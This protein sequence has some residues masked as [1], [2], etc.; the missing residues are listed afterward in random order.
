MRRPTSIV[1]SLKQQHK[2]RKRD[3]QRRQRR[4]LLTE[5][6]EDRRL[7]AGPDIIAIR[8]D[9]APLLEDG[10]TL[11]V[12][13]R[14]FNLLF[15]GGAD[16]DE[17]TIL[18][19]TTSGEPSIQLI[20]SGGDG[21]FTDGNE[22]VV[23]LGYVGVND[24]GSTDPANLQQLVLRPASSAA[25]NAT[26]PSVGMPDDTYRIEIFGDLASN[27]TPLRNGSGEAFRD[28]V[29]D[30][31][32]NGSDFF[33][34]FRLARGAQVV[35][36][37]PQPVS[38]NTYTLQ[39]D[40]NAT[41]GQFRVSV[42]GEVTGQILLSGDVR[43]NIEDAI[44]A[45]PNIQGVDANAHAP[46]H[47]AVIDLGTTPPSWEFQFKGQFATEEPVLAVD[48][49]DLTGPGSG[50][51]ITRSGELSQATDQ[52]LVYF[53][54]DEL[55][56]AAAED[57]KFYQLVYTAVSGSTADD[58]MLLP[59]RVS[60]DSVDNKA[61]LTFE[62]IPD[63][64]YRLDVGT[65]DESDDATDDVIRI[66]TLFNKTPFVN[67]A[68]ASFERLG[69]LGDDNATHNN[70][71]DVD[72][73]EF[74]VPPG[75]ATINV[76]AQPLTPG[77]DVTVAIA[78]Q[79]LPPNMAA[80]VTEN[81]NFALA[82]GTYT[83]QIENTAGFGAYDLQVSSTANIS[84]SDNN[85]TFAAATALG[86][87]GDAGVLFAA[88]IEPQNQGIHPALPQLPG[89]DDEPG[90]RH[91]QE[92]CHIPITGGTICDM[93]PATNPL[94]TLFG[95]PIVAT[96]P[97]R[98]TDIQDWYY[99][100]PSD[101]TDVVPGGPSV[102]D[103]LGLPYPNLISEPEKDVI[104][105]IYELYGSIA[106]I[107]FIEGRDTSTNTTM[108]LKGDLLAAGGTDTSGP[109]GILG[110]G[111]PAFLIMD[112]IDFPTS[113]VQFGDL[114]FF[115]AFH[116]VGHGLGLGHS[117]DL[118]SVMNALAG[119][120]PEQGSNQ[121]V[122]PGDHDV[123]HFQRLWRP[124]STDIDLY[125][126]ETE[127]DGYFTAEIYAERL[128]PNGARDDDSS[129][130]DSVLTLY[131][132]NLDGSREVIARNDNY[133]SNDSFVGLELEDGIYYL[134]VSST[135]NVN[136]DPEI[137]DSGFG[138]ATQ[139]AYELL[140]NLETAPPSAIVDLDGELTDSAGTRLD[141]DADGEPG[142][143]YHFW[144][145]A[146]Q[147]TIFADKA[148]NTI[149][150][151]VE[152]DGSSA[153]PYDTL[154]S[155]DP[156][157]PGAI[158]IA[159]H[160]LVVPA[161]WD[162][163]TVD[164]AVATNMLST[165]PAAITDGQTF[166]VDDGINFPV[167]FEFETGGGVT[168]GN[169]PVSFTAGDDAATVAAAIE[170]AIDLVAGTL[171][172]VGVDATATNEVVS[173]A[174]ISLLDERG[175][176]G[177]LSAPNI[178]RIVGNSG[179][180]GD[181][182]TLLDNRPYLL[183]LDASNDALADGEVLS[184][185]QGVT[186]MIDGG[187]LFKIKKSNLDVGTSSLGLNRAHAALQSLGTPQAQVHLDSYHN[188][189]V[190]GNS[191]GPGLVPVP[192]DF[193][194]IVLRGDSDHEDEG[195]FLN[196]VNHTNITHG[197]GLVPINADDL[198]FAPVHIADARPTVS[199][200]AI[201]N[202]ASS[203]LSANPNSFDDA[204]GRLGPDIDGN[205][206]MDNSINGL[207]IRIETDN[208][209]P[210]EKLL[211]GARFDDNDITH[212][213]T[214]NL[215][216]AG[217]AGG[218]TRENRP[219][220]PVLDLEIV[221]RLSG[222]LHIDPGTVIKLF[223]SRIELERGASNL[224]AEGNA[225]REVIFTSIDDDRFGGS[226]SFDGN[227][228]GVSTGSPGDWA[229]LIFQ[230]S[231]S[232][233]IDEALIAFG[234]GNV[235]IEGTS[236]SFNAIEV[237]QAELRLTNSV[238]ED[239]ASGLE[240]NSTRNGRGQNEATTI[241]VR[242]AQPVVVNNVI[243]DNAGSVISINDNSLRAEIRSDPGRA[244]GVI[245]AFDD[246]GDNHGPLIR[247]NR[248]GNDPANNAINGMEIRAST[249]LTTASVWD[250]TDIVHVL[251]NDQ[252]VVDN[253]HTFGG[254]RLQSSNSESLVVKL[255]G[256]TSA[257]F[258]ATG[259]P[260]EI[261]DRIGGTLQILGS[262]GHPVVITS[263]ADDT[264]GAGFTPSGLPLFD[265]NN[266]GPSTASLTAPAWNGILLDQF[267]NDRN[268]TVV[269]EDEDVFTQ[270][271]DVNDVSTKAQSLGVLAVNEKDGT[272]ISR[273][274]FEVHGA[275]ALDDRSDVDSYNFTAIAGTE[276]WID[277]DQTSSNLDAVVELVSNTGTVLV[278]SIGN[279]VAQNISGLDAFPLAEDV[280][281]GRDEYTTNFRDP[282]MRVLLP[283]QFGEKG[284]YF[285]RVRSNPAAG[286]ITNLEGGLTTGQY[287]LQIRLRQV[288][289]FSGSTV[290]LADIRYAQNGVSL[291]GLPAHSP[292]VSDASDPA[293]NTATIDLGNFLES[294][295]AAINIAGNLNTSTEDQRF[296]FDFNFDQPRGAA[297]RPTTAAV[298]FDVDYA[299]RVTRAD[300]TISVFDSA[301][302]L[303]YVG[304]ESNISDDQERPGQSPDT[305]E[306]DRGSF[307]RLDPF[308]GPVHLPEGA[309]NY[310]VVVGSNARL[311]NALD[312]F[313]QSN[314]TA[315]LTRLEAD[316]GH[317]PSRRRPHRFP[318]ATS[319]AARRR[320]R[321][322]STLTRPP[323]YS[324]T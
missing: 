228:N 226:G 268:V 307:S 106:G 35:A 311:P 8:P 214:E 16:I 254:L 137:V 315:P 312:Q 109:G 23:D 171:L 282:G 108:V 163:Q 250:D 96:D 321:T 42:D 186:T 132:E 246:L 279:H 210:V 297:D 139:G 281:L 157:M 79:P 32:D 7:L 197:G 240:A 6:L 67:G 105:E 287:R 95:D 181:I 107:Q 40:G 58:T 174:N 193:G 185:P 192:G 140:L 225:Q 270:K 304:R 27:A 292:L 296:T 81:H 68:L 301:N 59:T 164:L 9:E 128:L 120:L 29:A 56:K 180:D 313:F 253:L 288:D 272:E 150:N 196:Y 262:I 20:R 110:L 30:A 243:E 209:V 114:F 203:A 22:V 37:V 149:A 60:Y 166:I 103:P 291:R 322:S 126:F 267:S 168:A 266:N 155:I 141:G 198:V 259:T 152:G 249:K 127:A 234:G 93:D 57:P 100:F 25:H 94:V 111:S 173:I 12:A 221:E 90:H 82:P 306:L 54:D 257:G 47:V 199:F 295:R 17:S 213:I 286:N 218:P 66:G 184:V 19:S 236:A 238:I 11:N 113:N 39:V 36:V 195:I 99:Y 167:T 269:V 122:W 160:R 46:D 4:Q 55:D 49:A 219:G 323:T 204:G 142:G 153:D 305:E 44:Y 3:L 161:T 88:Q 134:G 233:S 190:G 303:I 119:N 64:T 280:R 245:D 182:N 62:S 222:R 51:T 183:G 136:Y 237:H 212:I 104:R 50:M 201:T 242:G 45:L 154:S 86:T 151:T 264:V 124:D 258:T 34:E 215:L 162:P 284:D 165:L 135:G 283:G 223:D 232:G 220:D 91:I 116:E 2:K 248:L 65:S 200:N 144:F 10:D 275:I 231:S 244:T 261:E 1:K 5:R 217:N 112:N 251:Q 227:E 33:R 206:V 77:L 21:T 129:L 133:F 38:R 252:I 63:G 260:L 289:E 263:L 191:D 177:L 205:L 211:V 156:A 317:Q 78:G 300:T 172:D 241:F 117:S 179:L 74:V 276:V 147:N 102:I 271:V 189:L 277:I 72:A 294:D 125:K 158:E 188:D 24:P 169:E 224:I 61:V 293:G 121:E 239:N 31:V 148:N 316:L 176:A 41:V 87:L 159:A 138:G 290:R 285:V 85:T 202:S 178:I 175:S 309:S 15:A 145:E 123:V 208:N 247:L 146:S 207:F 324:A 235:P 314:A 26:T 75:G 48:T 76:N 92:E 319:R 274:G 53:S 14:E 18:N 98:P 101:S 52:I 310:Q 130:L 216:I 229:G 265:T 194:G 13:P 83:L 97:V 89:D 84:V 256:G 273:L 255:A 170:T 73:Y 28:P 118:D 318:R 80:G 143:Q 131:R 70:V 298:V 308:I 302:R 187:A 69:Y 115:T 278:R 299:H 71:N 320:P 230:H 43:Q